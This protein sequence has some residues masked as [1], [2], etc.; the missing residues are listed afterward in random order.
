MAKPL[1][2]NGHPMDWRESKGERTVWSA[3]AA[4]FLVGV[5][6]V[7]LIDVFTGETANQTPVDI[8]VEV[9][10]SDVL[11]VAPGAE[12]RLL[13][14][15]QH[16]FQLLPAWE[17][18]PSSRAPYW[19]GLPDGMELPRV[20][21]GWSAAE[22][23]RRGQWDW[24][25]VSPDQP[26]STPERFELT[27]NVGSAEISF[28]WPDGRTHPCDQWRFGSWGC[29]LE[30]WLW[31]GPTEQ[32]FRGQP[33]ECIWAHPTD[34]AELV[35]RFTDVPNGSRL[36]GRYGIADSGA[37]MED[38]APVSMVVRAG[39]E[40]RR[41][42]AQNRHGMFSYHLA[43]SSEPGVDTIDIEFIISSEPAGRRHFC[44]TGAVVGSAE[45]RRQ[46]RIGHERAEEGTGAAPLPFRQFDTLIP[47][48]ELLQLPIREGR[49]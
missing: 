20:P 38:G 21:D 25:F 16:R 42:V 37:D 39:E 29:G 15:A 26:V 31:V 10:G 19:V 6:L 1:S 12:H 32:F 11:V 13:P 4:A 44:F 8:P 18:L 41:V 33:R 24:V 5:G 28:R 2:Y 36:A 17:N 34:G 47:Q 14:L 48:P 9:T 43:L 23:H 49:E 30:D 7:S 3:F 46:G 35:I 40:E 45:P 27:D 22:L